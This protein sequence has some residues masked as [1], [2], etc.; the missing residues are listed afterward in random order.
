ML[1][2]DKT[3]IE[4]LRFLDNIILFLINNCAGFSCSF[5]ELYKHIYKRNLQED[6][7]LNAKGYYTSILQSKKNDLS[8][9]F[10]LGNNIKADGEKL[11]EACY[12]LSIKNYVRLDNNFNLKIT[13]EGILKHSNSFVEEYNQ[14]KN[15]AK[16]D[17]ISGIF[18]VLLSLFSLILGY[19]LGK[20]N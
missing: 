10:T 5:D 11:V 7:E 18:N 12:F 14:N 15:K 9:I 19:Y 6:N 1:T 8:L 16:F 4:N 20:K 17:Y 2:R 13:F 3:H